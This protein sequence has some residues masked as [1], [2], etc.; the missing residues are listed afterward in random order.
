MSL[1]GTLSSIEKFVP[2]GRLHSRALQFYLKA[3]WNRKSFLDSFIFN[4]TPQIKEDLRW[5]LA[6]DRF[7]AGMSLTPTNPDLMLFSDASDLGWGA[8]LNNMEVSGTWSPSERNLHINM[9]ELKAIHL[10]LLHF[11]MITYHKTVAVHSDSMT[12]LAYIKNQGGTHSFTLNEATK[13]LLLWARSNETLLVT[14]FIHGKLNVLADELSRG[15]QVLPTE[16]SLNP[17]V[18]TDLWKLWGKPLIDL[19]A[20]SRNNRLPLY[21]S[22]APDPQ[23]WAT[24]AM[25]QDWS[26]LDLYAFP[27]FS[28]V[29]EVLRKFNS[30]VN[31]SVTLVAPF[32]P[33]KEWFPDLLSLLTDFPRLL[34]QRKSLLRQPH[35]L[36]YH[37][38]LSTLALTGF[39]LSGNLSER[40]DFQEWLQ[41]LLLTADDNLPLQ[42]TNPSGQF[43]GSGAKNKEFPLLKLP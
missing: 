1:L 28:M 37:Q 41:R 4:I 30:H 33:H 32:W 3:N 23:A 11:A 18:C 38:G 22:P 20:T 6:K 8:L 43:L 12:A 26:N 34:P 25:L 5:W 39:R 15:K 17:Q 14:R 2:L 36:R 42:S 31:V 13:E 7:S 16:W 10:A 9:K 21:C 24:D 19:F 35:F 27:P 29:K 40:K